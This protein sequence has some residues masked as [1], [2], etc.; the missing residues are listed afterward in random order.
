MHSELLKPVI[1]YKSLDC[2]LFAFL[3]HTKARIRNSGP[4]CV[5]NQACWGCIC[6]HKLHS[7]LLTAHF[8]PQQLSKETWLVIQTPCPSS[9][10][11]ARLSPRS[12]AQAM[13]ALDFNAVIASSNRRDSLGFRE[14]RYS[15]IQ[16]SGLSVVYEP[17]QDHP[18]IES[19][20][21]LLRELPPS[22]HPWC[23]DLGD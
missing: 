3:I 5:N 15:N 23:S 10:Y 20:L 13:S 4:L 2:W 7:P 21:I 12:L 6:A 1:N 16:D 19:V 17:A 11:D 8:Q 22:H 9:R 18:K 14:D